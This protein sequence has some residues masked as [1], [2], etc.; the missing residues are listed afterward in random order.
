MT[1]PLAHLRVLDLSRVL[2]GPFASQTLADLGADVIKIERPG[3]GDDTR[4]WG[5]PFAR[6]VNGH[7][8]SESAYYLSANRSKKSVC[9]DITTTQGQTL[10][11]ALAEQSDVVVE[12]FKVGHLAR[13]GLDAASLRG[14]NPRLIY[15][16]ITGFGQTGPYKD[17]PGYDFMIQGMGGLMS[18]TG[19]ADNLPGGGP[20]KTGV[21]ITDLTSGLYATIAIL[22]A[23]NRRT[24]TGLG[25]TIDISLLDCQ[26][27]MLANQAMNFLTTDRVP[28]RLGNAHPNIVP[29]QAF[30]TA[31]G[32][33]IIAVGNDGQFAALCQCLGQDAWSRDPRFATNRDRVINRD[34][35]V[36]DLEALVLTR[37]SAEWL[38]IFSS[39]NVPAGPINTLDHVFCD[40]QVIARGMSQS[41]PHALAGR[42]PTVASPI[43]FADADLATPTAPP[44]LG[45]HSDDVLQSRLGLSLVEIAQLRADRVIA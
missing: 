15:C 37:R 17:L 23:L 8:T 42:V 43:R 5:P 33:I 6:D 32:H 41:L 44:T 18:I 21:A 7:E 25:D 11:S 19:H 2:A 38:E 45:Q 24:L 20:M 27:A 1:L 30:A 36:A 14:L 13:Y 40:P 9:I 22:A 29:Y 39:A 16:S 28:Q 34:V 10:I 4:S 26:V 12:N 35:L 3:V 31:D